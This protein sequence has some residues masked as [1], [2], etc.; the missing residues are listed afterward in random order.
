MNRLTSIG[1]IL[2]IV[3][4][5]LISSNAQNQPQKVIKGGILNGKATSL[6]RPEYPA[7]ARAAALEGNVIVDVEIDESGLVTSAANSQFISKG[8]TPDAGE[9]TE[10]SPAES[11]LRQ[12]AER[13]ALEAR[14]SPTSIDGVP[15]KITGKLVYSFTL[16]PVPELTSSLL[17]GGVLNGK[18]TSLPSP[19]YPEAAKAVRAA[20]IVVVKVTI[21]ESG[22]VIA[23]SAVSGH[24][25]LRSAAV[26]AARNA[27]F[28]PT[29]ING[30]SV[31]VFGLVTYE[32]RGPKTD[33]N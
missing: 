8:K 2:V 29:L 32:F 10:V 15:V 4:V 7:E 13:A 6:P 26:D 16:G 23:A 11:A 24:P 28:P 17:N 9:T 25:L 12:A 5:S 30:Q 31:K 18:A 33:S 22:D 14:F 1:F 3:A 21:D 20:G 27:K 19:V